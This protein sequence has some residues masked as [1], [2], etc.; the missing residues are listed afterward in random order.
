[1]LFRSPDQAAL[2]AASERLES[3]LQQIDSTIGTVREIATNL[4]PAVLDD[5]GLVPALEWQAREF[6]ARSD[7][8]TE[9][10]LPDEELV[11][12]EARAAAVFRIFQELLTNIARHASARRIHGRLATDGNVLVLDVS[13]DGVRR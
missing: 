9:I 13:D 5:L 3:M 8:P 4:R 2:A 11:I 1:M 7:I 10:S 12:D 6:Q